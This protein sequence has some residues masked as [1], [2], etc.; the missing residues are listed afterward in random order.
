MFIIWEVFVR[1]F[2]QLFGNYLL[3]QSVITADKQKSLI[4]EM[5]DIRV[6]M[7]LLQ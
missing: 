6:K 2:T 5:K 7:E 3:E 4:N 1:M